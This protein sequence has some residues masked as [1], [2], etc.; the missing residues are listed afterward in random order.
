[1]QQLYKHKAVPGA[2]KPKSH[3][4]VKGN[5]GMGRMGFIMIYKGERGNLFIRNDYYDER[6]YPLVIKR[7]WRLLATTKE[8]VLKD[9][10]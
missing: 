4:L 10:H 1:M 5:Q 7:M 6:H 2:W 8:K 9:G 3:S